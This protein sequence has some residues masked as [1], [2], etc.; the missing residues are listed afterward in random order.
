VV[1]DFERRTVD[2]PEDYVECFSFVTPVIEMPLYLGWL[3]KRYDSLGGSL[4][5]RTIPDFNDLPDTFDIVVNCTGLE[6]GVL[7]DD[8]EVYPVR[9][10]IIRV[11]SSMSEMHLDQQIE[12]L[13]YIVPR[14]EDVVLGG[15]AQQGNWNLDLSDED[16]D[17]ILKKCSSIIPELRDAEI[18]EDLVALRP[19][20][21]VVRLEKEFIGDHSVVHNY[22]HGGSG[23]TLSWGCADEVVELVNG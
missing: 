1:Q 5:Q 11:R 3:R 21:T 8:S 6:S 2:L 13:T 10:Q 7:L 4:R 23:V 19:G 9:G 16:H 22:G 15:V 18:I 17:S 20:R 12:T 14:S